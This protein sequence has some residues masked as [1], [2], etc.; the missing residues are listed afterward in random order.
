MVAAIPPIIGPA[1]VDTASPSAATDLGTATTAAR[2]LN[3]SLTQDRLAR[4]VAANP[5][6][7]QL[8]QLLAQMQARRRR[9]WQQQQ[10]KEQRQ[11]SDGPMSLGRLAAMQKEREA[12]G[13]SCP[14]LTMLPPPPL[15]QVVD[16]EHQNA[17]LPVTRSGS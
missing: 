2:T 9:R 10:E 7:A 12:D 17:R 6:A 3:I 4:L 5:A 16:D 15:G 8:A 13:S 11:Q 1:L 14:E